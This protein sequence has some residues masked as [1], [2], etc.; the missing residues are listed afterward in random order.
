MKVI[1]CGKDAL[2]KYENRL[3]LYNEIKAYDGQIILV[4]SAFNDSPYSTKSLRTLLNNNYTIEMEQEIIVIGEIISSLR[5]TNELLN[6]Y[7]DATLLYKEEIGIYVEFSDKMEHIIRIDEIPIKS[8]LSNHKVLVVPGF[9]GIS[10]NNKIVSLNK[11][12][13]DLTALIMAKV[14]ECSDVYLY[15]NVLGLSSISPNIYS[16]YK[17]FK[18]VSYDLMLQNI[19]HGN[20]LVQEEALRFAKDNDINIH[21]QNYLNHDNETLITKFAKEKVIIFQ[22]N[23]NEIYIDGYNNKEQ[24]ENTLRL[25]NFE[26][27]YILPCNSFLKIVCNDNAKNVL[28]YLHNLYLKGEL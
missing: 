13:S 19:A 23:N 2:K 14:F 17:V 5:V 20:D 25:N 11:N 6:Q 28:L 9:I 27:D 12:G 26:F 24:I 1:K 15:K 7:I 10:Q 3:N 16:K 21:I 22:I 8:K 4:V 18:S